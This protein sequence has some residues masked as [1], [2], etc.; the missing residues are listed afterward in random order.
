MKKFL[1]NLLITI[2]VATGIFCFSPAQSQ[3]EFGV[4][5]GAIKSGINDKIQSSLF[6]FGTRSGEVLGIYYKKE[7]IWGL[8]GIQTEF[9]YQAK[10]GTYNIRYLPSEPNETA[11]FYSSDYGYENPD[12]NY[13]LKKPQRYH[14]FS[15]PI[16]ASLSPLK[17]LDVYAGPELNYM[18]A[19]SSTD[20]TEWKPNRMGI[21][22][23]AGVALKIDTNTKLDIRY[24]RDLTRVADFGDTDIKNYSWAFTVQRAIFK[25]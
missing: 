4:K 10:G 19:N 6:D 14:Y 7:N 12:R 24:S 16:L 5:G 2:L 13:W 17:I 18:F 1:P 23:A 3:N 15:I 11:S 22:L 9:L 25:K 21:G 20:Y 8:I